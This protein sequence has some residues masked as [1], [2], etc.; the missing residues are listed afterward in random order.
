MIFMKQYPIPAVGVIVER[1]GKI[2][3]I[4]KGRGIFLNQWCIP[5][6]KIEL[7][8]QINETIKREIL[9]ETCLEVDYPEFVTYQETIERD[10]DGNVNRHFVFFNFKVQYISGTPK[11]QDD[12]K[13]IGFFDILEL[14]NMDISLPTIKT[15]KLMGIM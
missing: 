15:F 7:G 9:E 13:E 5:G 1:E 14:Q 2:L 6:G 10:I 8:E 4:K 12:A 11:A 3:L